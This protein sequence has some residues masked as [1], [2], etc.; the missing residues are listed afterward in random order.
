MPSGVLQKKQRMGLFCCCCWVFFAGRCGL[1]C[2]N[3]GMC[4]PHSAELKGFS[5]QSFSGQA[6]PTPTEMMEV[7]KGPRCLQPSSLSQGPGPGWREGEKALGWGWAWMKHSHFFRRKGMALKFSKKKNAGTSSPPLFP[8]VVSNHC[9]ATK[10]SCFL[11]DYMCP[12]RL[13]KQGFK[14]PRHFPAS[15]RAT[16]PLGPFW[17]LSSYL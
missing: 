3:E 15:L 1:S 2:G 4:K 11:T 6:W 16:L 7:S 10:W 8:S 14:H 12:G 9:L 17:P 5:L 13:F